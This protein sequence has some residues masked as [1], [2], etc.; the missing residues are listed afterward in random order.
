MALGVVL[1]LHW[2]RV[3]RDVR[4]AAR[5]RADA[6]DGWAYRDA[7]GEADARE[8]LPASGAFWTAAG[9]PAEWRLH[10]GA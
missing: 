1:A 7:G 2:W 6:D 8:V 5:L 4:A 10:H 3:V 9:V